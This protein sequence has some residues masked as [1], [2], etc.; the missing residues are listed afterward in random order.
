MHVFKAKNAFFS[1]DLALDNNTVRTLV[2][3]GIHF[4]HRVG[5]WNPKMKPYIFC[6]RNSIH[7]INIKET[8]KGMVRARKFLASIVGSGKDVLFV[9]TK[10]Q[11]R[12]PVVEQAIRCGMP[13]VCERWL[14]GTL[15][16]FSTIRKR[17]GRLDELEDMEEKGLLAA[18]SKKMEATMRRELRK[19]KRNL[20]GIR[21]MERIPGVLVIID[22]Q[23]EHLAVA[24]ARKLKIPTICLLDTDSN[25]DLVDI[26]IPGNDDAMR[27]IEIIVTQMADAVMEG[28]AVQKD[29]PAAGDGA[30]ARGSSRRTSTSQA[31][32]GIAQGVVK[33]EQPS[34]TATNTGAV[35]ETPSAQPGQDQNAQN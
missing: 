9:G 6:S 35:T 22:A 12:I 19:I 1:G 5:R 8:I 15:T 11:A 3:A 30:G 2:D 10:R 17:L 33:T 28:K 27:V 18:Q 29:S 23:R 26:P 13:Y 21:N 32:E 16:N 31:A 4:G 14:G 7:I 24:E 25:P 20:D 34:P